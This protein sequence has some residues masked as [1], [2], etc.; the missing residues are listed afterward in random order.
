MLW[1]KKSFLLVSIRALLRFENC[2]RI[3]Y[4]SQ[5]RG[6]I[7]GMNDKFFD[8]KSE[9]QDRMINA[10][11]KIFA[12]N[13][14]KHASTDDIVREAGIS[15]GLLFHYFINKMGLYSFL[16]DYSVRYMN[17]EF[18][19]TIGEETDYFGF[20]E[21]METAKLNVLKNYPYMNEFIDNCIAENR[22]DLEESGKEAIRTYKD[23]FAA[24]RAKVKT[25][26]L[27]A[28]VDIEQLENMISYTIKGIT[29]ESVDSPNF[30]PERLNQKVIEY[31]Q[32]FKKLAVN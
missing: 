21:K 3:V 28:G 11:L 2:D 10:S 23:T 13:G 24:Y 19:R 4:A 29:A 31:L 27:K 8:L 15:K 32:A 14:Y 18:S 30:K 26:S 20:L 5:Q 1:V 17:F 12:T 16:L 6:F 7:S 22:I 9:K 25:P